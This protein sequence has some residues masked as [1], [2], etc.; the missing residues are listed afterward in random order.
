MAGLFQQ[1]QE[2]YYQQSQTFDGNGTA[3][4]FTLL[5]THFPSIPSSKSDI[6]VFVGGQEIDVDN[7][8]YSSP[9]VTFVGRTNNTDVLA[10][11]TDGTT[12]NAPIDGKSVVV[13]ERA[14]SENFGNY[15]YV[16]VNDIVNNF[17]IAYVGEG[18]LINKVSKTDVAFHAKRGLAEFSYDTLRSHKSQ[19]IEVPP[20]LILPLP[21][22]YVNYTKISQLDANGVKNILYPQRYTGNPKSLLQNADYDYIF[23]NSGDLLEK[24]PSTTFERYKDNNQTQTQEKLNL[25]D[26]ADVEF[27]F[28]E[29]RR[30]GLEPELAQNNGFY[31]VDLHLGRIH[32][33][34]NLVDEIVVIDYISDTLGTDDEMRIHK[35]AEEAL[36]KHISYSVLAS[37]VGIPEY[38]VARY[39]KER[40][41]ALRNAKLRLSN[42][43]SE[44]LAQVMRNKNKTIKN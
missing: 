15:Q 3:T 42:F 37:K 20:S 34:A 32:F 2:S 40:F 4:Q 25:D 30:F 10:D 38:I 21:H 33:S 6:R 18:K 11:G 7:Y 27:K 9:N 19:E 22:D 5:N 36:Y 35:F 26:S 16:S 41:A 28:L 8:T 31:F 23:D 12:A 1:T 39:K 43:K 29:G 13:K 17:L 14:A 24:S 44:E